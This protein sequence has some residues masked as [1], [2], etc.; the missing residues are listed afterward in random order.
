MRKV[1]LPIFA[2]VTAISSLAGVQGVSY[3]EETNQTELWSKAIKE[4]QSK[5]KDNDRYI[6]L[7]EAK[8]AEKKLMLE[9]ARRQ[10]LPISEL[11][12]EI[13]KLQRERAIRF[14]SGKRWKVELN[15]VTKPAEGISR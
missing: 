13:D 8:I 7:C 10:S 11:E 12:S 6:D 3:A 14:D 5:V 15:S 1:L 4:M 2:I 9:E